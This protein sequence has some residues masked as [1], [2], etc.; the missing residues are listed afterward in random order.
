ML[1]N[2]HRCAAHS[3]DTLNRV[4]NPR[5]AFRI[6]VCG[7]LI[8][9]QKTG[10]HRQNR[11]ECE[12]LFLTARQHRRIAITA[13]IQANRFQSGINARPNLFARNP[14]VL[15]AERHVITDARKHNLS[16]RILHHQAD[17]TAKI[18]RLLLLDQ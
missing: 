5:N 10:L 9:K 6:K 1:N 7:R 8:K 15:H 2:D 11:R 3:K 16:L 18:L 13:D 4:A 12:A 17:A 14:E